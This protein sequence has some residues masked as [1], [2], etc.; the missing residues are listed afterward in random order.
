MP[1]FTC[2]ICSEEKELGQMTLCGNGH[3]GG[4]QKCH[5][6]F[7]KEQYK[8]DI[9]VFNK[10]ECT[11]QTCMF[12]REDLADFQMGD[13]WA[14]R[15]HRLQPI[16]MYQSAKKHGYDIEESLLELITKYNERVPTPPPFK[17]DM[18]I[19][20]LKEARFDGSL[21]LLCKVVGLFT[22]GMTYSEMKKMLLDWMPAY[23]EGSD[24]IEVYEIKISGKDYFKDTTGKIYDPESKEVVGMEKDGKVYKLS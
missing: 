7:I 9:E 4:C 22:D 6:Q 24:S 3:F 20:V 8:T 5:L 15:L 11:I 19:D 14:M 12:C 21:K 17:Y 13:N 18:F 23:E 16:M 10:Q 1:L 2:E